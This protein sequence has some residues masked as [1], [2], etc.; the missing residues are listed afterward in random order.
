[1]IGRRLH[2]VLALLLVS[3]AAL[4]FI[5]LGSTEIQSWDE[6]LYAL[7]TDAALNSC[8]WIDQT[9]ESPGGLYSSTHPPAAIWFMA[10]SEELFGRNEWSLRLP[11]ALLAACSVWLLYKL[12]SGVA[13]RNAAALATL[14]VAVSGVFVHLARH[15]QLDI[16]L[17]F[18]VLLSL[19]VFARAKDPSTLGTILL[20]GLLFGLALLSKF[21]FALVL[22][23]MFLVVRPSVRSRSVFALLTVGVALALPWYVWMRMQHPEFG[24][25]ALSVASNAAYEGTQHAWWFYANQVIIAMPLTATMLVP[26]AYDRSKRTILSLLAI[27]IGVMVLVAMATSLASYVLLILLPLA[28]F[29]ATAI[30]RV[31]QSSRPAQFF[32]LAV[33][34]LATFWAASEQVRMLVKGIRGFELIIPIGEIII[35]LLLFVWALVF[36]RRQPL[37]VLASASILAAFLGQ[38]LYSAGTTSSSERGARM[39]AEDLQK[40]PAKKP[41]VLTGDAPHEELM[42]QLSYYFAGRQVSKIRER[43]WTGSVDSFDAAIVQR[44]KDRLAVLSSDQQASWRKTDSL[45]AQQFTRKLRSGSYF[46]Y[47]GSRQ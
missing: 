28:L 20:P 17:F 34:S 7:R 39:L 2:P 40:L 42:P 35:V 21:G 12:L 22:A 38:R 16:Y 8:N 10:A 41:L 46:L 45:L 27:L 32:A 14:S 9:S 31:Q 36:L 23:P 25:H 29:L 6:G 1:M 13:S 11:G 18:F 30:D 4:L 37:L 43:E 3:A 44:R 33:I 19:Y 24:L 47:F 26:F 15:A 5:R